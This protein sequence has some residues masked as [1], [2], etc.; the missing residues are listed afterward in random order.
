MQKIKIFYNEKILNCNY[1]KTPTPF[2]VGD[3][4][5][6]N[7]EE[8]EKTFPDKY[9]IMKGMDQSER[10]FQA[11]M[12]SYNY[13]NEPWKNFI[14]YHTNKEY[15]EKTCL[16][17]QDEL[18]RWRPKLWEKIKSGNYTYGY[19]ATKDEKNSKLDISYK[20]LYVV[21]T[22]YM[23]RC[24]MGPHVDNQ[25]KV[26]QLM[27]YFKHPKDNSSDGNFHTCNIMSDNSIR[28]KI[29]CKYIQNRFVI[30][31]HTPSGWH[32]VSPSNRIYDR[33]MINVVFT[34]NEKLQEIDHKFFGE[35][36]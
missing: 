14:D 12:D 30:L 2:I 35:K 17:I 33:K 36:I 9:L 31:P 15:F 1:I 23:N 4:Y 8:L 21:D 11:Y 6:D 28:N 22:E 34:I 24:G 25:L 20:F 19:C 18:I 29:K 7:Y 16:V 27:V 3:N 10:H 32:F 5:C 26:F 13:K